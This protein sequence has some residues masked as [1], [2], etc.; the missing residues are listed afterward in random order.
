V[1]DVIHVNVTQQVQTFPRTKLEKAKNYEM[2]DVQA[3]RGGV[4]TKK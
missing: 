2:D 3:S 1:L 4:N